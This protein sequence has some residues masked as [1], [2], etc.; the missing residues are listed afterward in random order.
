MKQVDYIIYT[1][2]QYAAA[3]AG[4]PYQPERGHQ[5]DF[6]AKLA[7]LGI[8]ACEFAGAGTMRLFDRKLLTD[9]APISFNDR[10]VK[11]K[12]AEAVRANQK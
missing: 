12:V 1:V 10:V 9:Y 5:F 8:P 3:W 2:N 11:A 6:R 7:E 4:E